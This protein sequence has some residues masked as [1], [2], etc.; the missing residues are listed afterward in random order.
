MIGCRVS[1]VVAL[2]IGDNSIRSKTA[3]PDSA[4]RGPSREGAGAILNDMEKRMGYSSPKK[5]LDLKEFLSIPAKKRSGG[6]GFGPRKYPMTAAKR[7]DDTPEKSDDR[8]S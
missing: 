4:L 5:Q 6:K 2:F 1:A 7:D 8:D 3:S